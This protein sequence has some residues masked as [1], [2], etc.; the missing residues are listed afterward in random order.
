[1]VVPVDNK[2]NP[3]WAPGCV[4]AGGIPW[5]QWS[6]D[7]ESMQRSWGLKLRALKTD[8]EHRIPADAVSLASARNL[9]A[10]IRIVEA[11]TLWKYGPSRSQQGSRIKNSRVEGHDCWAVERQEG[12]SK[13]QLSWDR[14]FERGKLRVEA[15][16]YCKF[17]G[18]EVGVWGGEGT[19]RVFE[20]GGRK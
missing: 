3:D 10:K 17:E 5:L 4:V 19:G 8:S 11:R 15:K 6:F 16:D 18:A 12:K 20:E 9:K 2:E 14:S 7:C 1:M 13:A